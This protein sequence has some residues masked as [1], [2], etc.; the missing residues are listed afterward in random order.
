MLVLAAENGLQREPASL[1]LQS[2]QHPGEPLSDLM[3]ISDTCTSYEH[4]FASTHI[5]GGGS[6]LAR[7]VF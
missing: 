1:D 7:P 6:E 4:T 3:L 2:R 5:S